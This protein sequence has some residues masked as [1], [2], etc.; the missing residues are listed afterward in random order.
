MASLSMASR[1]LQT[2]DLLL[3]SGTGISSDIIRWFTGSSWTHIGVVVHLEGI[4]EPL[5]LEATMAAES[6]DLFSGELTSGVSLVSLSQKLADYA[7][8][9]AVRHRV[10]PPLCSRQRRLVR[11]LVR[12]LYRKPY[13]NYVWRQLL[14]AMPLSRRRLGGGFFCSELVAEFYRRLGWLPRDIRC[15]GFVPGHFAEESLALSQGDL[16]PLLWLKQ[17][18]REVK[19]KKSTLAVAGR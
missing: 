3:F 4:E 19:E 14:D 13:R 6:L 9:V 15:G 1:S 18:L 16:L 5:L 2:G 10:G 17:A 12:C 8:D 7:G 11:R